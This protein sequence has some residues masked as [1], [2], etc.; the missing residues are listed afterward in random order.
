[1]PKNSSKE[2]LSRDNR[3]SQQSYGAGR[4]K[5]SFAGRSVTV[6]QKSGGVTRIVSYEDSQRGGE[7]PLPA[8]KSASAASSYA[9]FR[10]QPEVLRRNRYHP[11]P[12]PIL[13]SGAERGIFATRQIWVHSGVGD[14]NPLQFWVH[15]QDRILDL[16]HRMMFKSNE[17]EPLALFHYALPRNVDCRQTKI[18]FAELDLAYGGQGSTLHMSKNVSK[19]AWEFTVSHAYDF[20]STV[21]RELTGIGPADSIRD[22]GRVLLHVPADQHCREH[23]ADDQGYR[24]ASLLCSLWN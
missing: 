14:K 9:V 11:Q 8:K 17:G 4:S 20:A 10:P 22:H 23:H 6:S 21:C 1:M 7:A 2:S 19:G 15:D 13:M 5:E 18:E 16:C 3:S 12:E 24:P